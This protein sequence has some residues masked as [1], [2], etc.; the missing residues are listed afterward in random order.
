MMI[1]PGYK[2][3]PT[4]LYIEEHSSLTFAHEGGS[5]RKLSQASARHGGT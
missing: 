3:K 2:G 4:H 5:F 1:A